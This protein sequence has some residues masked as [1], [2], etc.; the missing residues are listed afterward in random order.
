[1]SLEFKEVVVPQMGV[2]DESAIIVEWAVAPGAAVRP[3]QVIATLETTKASVE[4]EAEDEGHLYPLAEAGES[5]SIRAVVAILTP[6]PMPD[7]VERYRTVQVHEPPMPSLPDHQP[8]EGVR[9]TARARRLMER[10]GVDPAVLPRDRIVRERD[11]ELLAQSAP[12][13]HATHQ[14]AVRRIA[15]VGASQ[16]GQVCFEY[17]RQIEAYEVLGFVEDAPALV[18]SRVRGL[19]VWSGADLAALRHHGVE[20]LT[21]HIGHK[22]RRL[23]LLQRAR[24]A[25]LP[26]INL[27]HPHSY[28]SPSVVMGEGN[29][30]KAGAVVD[31]EVQMGDCCIID[32]GVIVPHHN[33]FGDACHLAPGVSFGGDCEVG[34]R[35][36]IGIGAA[37]S[38]RLRIGSNVIIGPGAIV[39]RD[40][41]DNVVVEGRPARVVG[42][43]KAD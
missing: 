11:I 7:A 38:P 29:L 27:I 4:L 14:P 20:G 2:N 30:I 34:D 8:V 5:V 40:V 6:A 15:I 32:N 31:S 35:T 12:P 10:Y 42:E 25:G 24:A 23:A 36:V 28:V 26:M 16:G 9:L 19:P 37:I 3:G 18:G 13:A 41:P 17:L 39:V 21:T 22:D 33:R 1:M 43:L